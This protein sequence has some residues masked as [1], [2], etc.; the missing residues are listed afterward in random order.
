MVADL[1]QKLYN[2][3]FI[4]LTDERIEGPRWLVLS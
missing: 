4:K 2:V 3:N 1:L